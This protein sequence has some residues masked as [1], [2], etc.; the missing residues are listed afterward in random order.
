LKTA[1][2]SRVDIHSMHSTILFYHFRLVIYLNK[3]TYRNLFPLFRRVIIL[4]FEPTVITKF[5]RNPSVGAL[6]MGWKNL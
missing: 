4:V 1:L 6:N 2:L 3:C 5:P